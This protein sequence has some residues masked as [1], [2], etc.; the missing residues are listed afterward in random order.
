MQIPGVSGHGVGVEEQE[1]PGLRVTERLW[2]G[3]RDGLGW[4]NPESS[5]E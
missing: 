1:I 3:E 2:R 5:V 4:T